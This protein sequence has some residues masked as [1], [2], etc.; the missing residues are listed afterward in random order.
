MA[1]WNFADLWEANAHKFPDATAQVHGERRSTWQEFDA[2]ANGLARYLLDGGAVHR[3]VE[4]VVQRM[5]VQDED[6][7][8]VVAAGQLPIRSAS[9]SRL[10]QCR[11]LPSRAVT[12][13]GCAAPNSSGRSM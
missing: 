12:S 4:A 3:S 5:A 11:S 1:G 9:A 6:A 7:H 8:G 2:R 10:R 13:L